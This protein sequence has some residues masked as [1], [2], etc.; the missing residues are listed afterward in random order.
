MTQNSPRIDVEVTRDKEMP[1]IGED[2][3]LQFTFTNKTGGTVTCKEILIDLSAGDAVD[4][5]ATTAAVRSA[6]YD[7]GTDDGWA[8]RAPTQSP[9]L[10]SLRPQSKDVY[11]EDQDSITRD[12]KVT[13]NTALNSGGSPTSANVTVI[14]KTITINHEDFHPDDQVTPVPKYGAG[15]VFDDF[16]P[17]PPEDI[18][19]KQGDPVAL[20]WTFD[21]KDYQQGFTQG[22]AY[23][24]FHIDYIGPTGQSVG[25]MD[26]THGYN[27]GTGWFYTGPPGY[28]KTLALPRT[29]PFALTLDLYDG[30]NQHTARHTLYT[31][32]TVAET[33]V[34]LGGLT[35]QGTAGILGK[36][37]PTPFPHN[38]EL[39]ATT[40]GLL[41]CTA[42]DKHANILIRVTPPGTKEQTTYGITQAQDQCTFPHFYTGTRILLP[43]T[44][45]TTLKLTPHGACAT[46]W[47]PIGTG[48]L[49]PTTK[50]LKK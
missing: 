9:Y 22:K 35:V 42:Q 10:F 32:V 41:L 3:T 23:Y 24:T 18:L 27:Q 12:I 4:N 2:L 11:L 16:R 38:T 13:L 34:D 45:N 20:S 14:E 7:A 48:T 29:T 25:P 46:Q 36:P 17:S 49:T 6:H 50:I 30:T 8:L 44:K 19:V 21:A 39:T 37:D 28:P 26:V 33:D 40:D 31:L 43:I 47:Y 1:A 15:T 5:L